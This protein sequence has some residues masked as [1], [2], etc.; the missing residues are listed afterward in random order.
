MEDQKYIL[1]EILGVAAEQDVDAILV[2]GDVMD[3]TRAGEDVFAA[4]NWFMNQASGYPLYVIPGNHDPAEKLGCCR[5]LM[6]EGIYVCGPYRGKAE[7]YTVTD[8]YGELNIFLLPYIK[9]STV[10]H[11][12][13]DESV[14]TPENAFAKTFAASDIDPSARNV[15]VCHQFV[16][17]SGIELLRSDSEE[18]SPVVGGADCVS[19]EALKDFDYVALGHIHGA[20][21]AGRPEVRY[22]GSPLKYSESEKEAKTVTIVDIGKKGDVRISTVPLVPQRDLKCVEGTVDEILAQAPVLGDCYLIASV[23]GNTENAREK[24]ASKF[25]HLM[26]VGYAGSPETMTGEDLNVT[27]DEIGA[28][29]IESLFAKFYSSVTGE[30]LTE[31]QSEILREACARVREAMQ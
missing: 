23:R 28:G 15:L 24:L 14:A 16:V 18:S 27:V 17:G 21:S 11:Y 5:S 25:P 22:C 10:R 12:Y 1:E 19:Y 30:D 29:D 13:E 7:K 9:T 26:N 3:S 8:E 2:A 4:Y 6:R 31:T 20:Q